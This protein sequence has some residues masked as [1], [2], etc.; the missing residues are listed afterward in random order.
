MS[1][2][3]SCVLAL[4]QLVPLSLWDCGQGVCG[5]QVAM[6]HPCHSMAIHVEKSESKQLSNC[7]SQAAEQATHDAPSQRAAVS[8]L[9]TTSPRQ[10][11]SPSF[12]SPMPMSWQMYRFGSGRLVADLPC[13][14]MAWHVY[15][16]IAGDRRFRCHSAANYAFRPR[17]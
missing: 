2:W 17:V 6:V 8:M 1:L 7:C 15:R 10:R 12:R 3:M 11:C 5:D 13:V 4:M 14:S 16:Q 9:M